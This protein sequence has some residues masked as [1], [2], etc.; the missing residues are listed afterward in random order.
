[1]QE[2]RYQLLESWITRNADETLARGVIIAES[3]TPGEM[4]VFTGNLGSGKTTLIQGICRGLGVEETVTSPTFTLINEYRGRLPVY[5]FD[6]Y[7]LHSAVELTDLG[8]EEY[9]YGDGICLVEWPE[10]IAEW[11][12]VRHIRLHLE[13]GIHAAGRINALQA[14][15]QL[16]PVPI[17]PDVR[18]IEVYRHEPARD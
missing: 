15:Q 1:V 14:E 10:L 9:L 16:E 11:L 5:H 12:P 17:T 4:L 18:L 13:H 3:L 6:F 7:R 2:S 8:L